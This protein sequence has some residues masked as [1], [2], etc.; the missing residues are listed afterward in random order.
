MRDNL[1]CFFS[2]AQK[3]ETLPGDSCDLVNFAFF[4]QR[5]DCRQVNTGG[6]KT[7]CGVNDGVE[8]KGESVCVCVC[9]CNVEV[10]AGRALG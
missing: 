6:W 8:E 5:P 3:R 7:I 9:W 1:K 4:W 10:M 2:F